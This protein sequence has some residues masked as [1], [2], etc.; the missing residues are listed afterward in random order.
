MHSKQVTVKLIIATKYSKDGSTYVEKSHRHKGHAA[1][2]PGV[3]GQDPGLSKAARHNLK[4]SRCYE[5]HTDLNDMRSDVC[6]TFK[7][8]FHCVCVSTRANQYIQY[9]VFIMS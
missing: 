2:R 4:C 5:I 7:H 9:L 8:I 3:R 6:N 1:A